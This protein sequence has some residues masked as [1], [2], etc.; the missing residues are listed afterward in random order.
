M[1]KAYDFK[2]LAAILKSNGLEL[3]EEAAEIV[4]KST[5]EWFEKS[6]QLSETKYDDLMLAV[7]PL[8]KP[9]VMKQ[10]DKIDGVEG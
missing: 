7:L 10:V 3:A 1:E 5:F 2:A 8:V 6:A 9:L 4:A